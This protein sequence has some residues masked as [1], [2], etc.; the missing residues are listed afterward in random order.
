MAAMRLIGD[1]RYSIAIV[2]DRRYAIVRNGDVLERVRRIGPA[3]NPVIWEI[4]RPLTNELL[5][6]IAAEMASE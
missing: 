1:Y 4:G 6:A 5:D 3:G 2:E